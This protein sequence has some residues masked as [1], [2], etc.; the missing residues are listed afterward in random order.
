MIVKKCRILFILLI[1][2]NEI[3]KLVQC[4]TQISN[5]NLHLE[6]F[7][8]KSLIRF[9]D[10]ND[11]EVILEDLCIRDL[12][13]YLDGKLSFPVNSHPKISNKNCI[14]LTFFYHRITKKF[15]MGL[16]MWVLS[17]EFKSCILAKRKPKTKLW[18]FWWKWRKFKNLYLSS[19]L[20][21]IHPYTIMINYVF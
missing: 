11:S 10:F 9:F 3:F 6:L 8:P 4:S 13:L 7:T 17:F 21:K 12:Y 18:N 16:Q 20:I 1:S 2:S 14:P 15:Q 19:Y 5:V